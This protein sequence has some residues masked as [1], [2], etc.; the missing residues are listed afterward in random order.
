MVKVKA[1]QSFAHGNL[2]L[3]RG[4]EVEIST[5]LAADLE[6]NGL[7]TIAASKKAPAPENKA[8]P[9]PENKMADAPKNKTA[10]KAK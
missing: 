10:T 6:K 8:A 3:S 7:V 9:E 5:A 4:D 1:N 2:N